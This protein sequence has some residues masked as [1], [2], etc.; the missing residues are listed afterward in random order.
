MEFDVER[1]LKWKC[2]CGWC[3][4]G[5][6]AAQLVWCSCHIGFLLHSFKFIFTIVAYAGAHCNSIRG[7]VTL[8]GS[9][10][11]WV[12]EIFKECQIKHGNTIFKR[13]EWSNNII[14]HCLWRVLGRKKLRD[15]SELDRFDSISYFCIHLVA[16]A[17]LQVS[18]VCLC[19]SRPPFSYKRF[20][21]S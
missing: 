8:A 3:I 10:W 18:P 5:L 9:R 2:R 16:L 4:F 17:I 1:P 19:F 11:M 12:E 21:I 13:M 15:I 20:R 14:L 7:I 6:L